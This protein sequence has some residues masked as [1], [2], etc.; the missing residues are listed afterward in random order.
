MW[1]DNDVGFQSVFG[2]RHVA[3][4]NDVPASTFL[5]MA[6]GELISIHGFPQGANTHFREVVAV[7]I[8]PGIILVDI[9]VFVRAEGLAL[10][11][12]LDGFRRVIAVLLNR[13]D[14]RNDD[15]AILHLRVLRNESLRIQ[16]VVIAVLDSLR[17]LLVRFAANN[18]V[19][20]NIVVFVFFRMVNRC[21]EK[22]AVNRS[23]VNQHTIL[24]IIT[25]MGHNGDVY[26]LS[27]RYLIKF[28]KIHETGVD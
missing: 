8:T 21:H 20:H 18:L 19:A 13:N 2:E 4:G 6:R 12:V 10:V 3:L 23:L 28:D 26:L 15:V 17:L 16:F 27:R 22:P 11:L 7:A 1:I 9:G 14:F 24:L 5:A 25:R